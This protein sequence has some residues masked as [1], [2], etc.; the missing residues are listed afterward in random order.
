MQC[1]DWNGATATTCSPSCFYPATVPRSICASTRSQ[2]VSQSLHAHFPTI[3][4]SPLYQSCSHISPLYPF[5]RYTNP[6][7]TF[8]HYTHFPVIP[9]LLPHFH[10]IPISPL[11]QS[12]SH[13]SPLYPFPRY[14]NPAPTFPH[15]THFPVIPILLPHFP[16]IL[17]HFLP[18]ILD[19]THDN[20]GQGGI[21]LSQDPRR[22]EY[23]I[24][25][26]SSDLLYTYLHG[27]SVYVV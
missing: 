10:T 7:P 24:H 17:E 19:I 26:T 21:E 20:R 18:I 1:A 16:T 22:G 13:I 12:C 5:P 11:Y 15:Y 14:T 2:V 27:I 6:A 4:I 8:P 9:I 3:P 23:S 25:P